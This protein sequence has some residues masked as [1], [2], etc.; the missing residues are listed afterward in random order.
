MLHDPLKIKPF[1]TL[2]NNETHIKV[3]QRGNVKGLKRP[4]IAQLK[5][6]SLF[7]KFLRLGRSYSFSSL[8][9][10]CSLMWICLG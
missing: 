3:S 7:N 2:L 10:A 6:I 5:V 1:L 8:T 4:D 9:S